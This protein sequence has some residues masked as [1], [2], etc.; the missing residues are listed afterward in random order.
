MIWKIRVEDMIQGYAQQEDGCTC[1][2]CG[3]KF[4]Q[5]RIYEMDGALYDA[6]GA[7]KR[8]VT[9]KHGNTADFLL[10]KEPGAIGISEAQRQILM[11]MSEGLDDK[12]I[13]QRMEVAPS[14]VRNHRFKLREKE[15]QARLFLA[16]MGA[17][18]QKTDRQMEKSDQGVLEEV[19][20][21]ATMTDERYS[22]TE[23]EREKVLAA[24]MDENGALKQFP[25]RE[26][27]K[28]IV[29]RE[30]MKNFKSGAQYT[31]KEVNRVLQRIYEAD[32]PTLRR[33]LIEYGFME[34]TKD[35]SVY[36]VKE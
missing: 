17:L 15:K 10:E 27:K 22:I 4:E 19:H 20:L 11:L 23:K 33:Y 28:I 30:I 25:A 3:E 9:G 8:H 5:G 35:C 16:L 36:R 29:L 7:V 18:E 34:R 24:Y 6:C 32:Y 21:A 14:T 12:Q 13:A 2:L 1:V 26:K 31:E